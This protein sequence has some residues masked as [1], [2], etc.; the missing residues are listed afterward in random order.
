[1]ARKK[2]GRTD[3]D[4][5]DELKTRHEYGHDEWADIRKEGG[6]DM[7]FVAGDPWEKE[8]RKAR[9]ALSRP[10]LE[11]DELNQ[12]L[13]QAINN[14]RQNKRGIKVSQA[15]AGATD[16]TAR[17]RQGKIRDIEYRSKA[18]T[19]YL[20][21][22]ENVFQRGYG[23]L[24]VKTDWVDDTILAGQELLI[25]PVVNPDCVTPDPDHL[26]QTGADLDWLFYEETWKIE[27]FKRKFPKARIKDF[28]LEVQQR[29]GKRWFKKTGTIQ[30]AEYWTKE[31][32]GERERLLLKPA[33]GGP[34]VPLDVWADDLPSA[35]PSD[36]ILKRRMVAQ[37]SIV[38]YLSNGV[39]ILERSEW[40]GKKS[41]P[42]VCCYGK[43]LYVDQGE[44]AKKHLLSAVRLARSPQM[45]YAYYRTQQAEMAGMIPKAPVMAY[46]GQ[47]DGLKHDWAKSMHE[48]VAFLFA[49][50][51]TEATGDQILPLPVRLAYEAGEHLQALELCA[52][53]ARRAIQSAMGIT[54]L[55]TSA[56]RRNEKSGVAL[57]H[58]DDS[59]IKGSFHFVDHY[60]ESI[61]RTGEILDEN[62]SV[63]HDTAQD[64]TV[65]TP[66]D[67]VETVRVN[68]P[69]WQDPKTG[70]PRHIDTTLGRHN[71]TISIGPAQDSEREAASDFADT[72]LQSQE[73]MAVAGPQRAA[74]IVAA[75]IRLKDVGPI[76]DSMAELFDP[77]DA[78]SD[79]SLLKQQASELH[80]QLQQTQQQLQ[81]AA[82]EI[83]TDR[84]KVDAQVQMKREELDFKKWQAERDSETKIAVAE[85][86]AKVDRLALFMEE[87]ARLGLADQANEDRAHEVGMAAVDHVHS[88]AQ[89][90][91]A[92]QHAAAAAEQGQGHA[93]EQGEQAHGQAL[94]AG[95][96]GHQQALEQQAAAQP[97]AGA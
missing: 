26:R 84:Y 45:L 8:D 48:P 3:A 51:K 93:L 50:A 12:Y 62:L 28:A 92:A 70:Q 55:P 43:V 5:L 71:I 79:P 10:V 74:K 72:I 88:T 86:G 57:K 17:W 29:A 54:P 49:K 30:V 6:I 94:E 80:Q 35:P 75:A 38:K 66:T 21:M 27:D 58:I 69:Q 23:F 96:V 83:K 2:S 65:R 60:N 16:D 9:Q 87:R 33:P 7:R 20:T 42:W 73:V 68:D 1:M 63:V 78:S 41:I 47:L 25:E 18:Q 36:Q 89:A 90:Q 52:E 44:G 46:E 22:V 39:E 37:S 19:A 82:E 32:A 67:K 11:V 81:A 61:E 64:T 15:G 56:Q 85:L 91:Q 4:V 95:D 97:E 76:G 24:R 77:Q 34:Q 13:N 53:G 14:L 40:G 31:S 59:E